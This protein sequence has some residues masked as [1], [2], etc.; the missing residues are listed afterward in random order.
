M[1]L[2]EDEKIDEFRECLRRIKQIALEETYTSQSKKTLENVQEELKK[3]YFILK[4]VIYDNKPLNTIEFQELKEFFYDIL[5][6]N[7]RSFTFQN[8]LEYYLKR[9]LIE[10]PFIIDEK[11][12][13]SQTLPSNINNIIG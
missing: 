5:K 6:D 2:T 13:N 3:I 11:V 4:P 7:N 8:S 10:Y 1:E 9:D 12:I